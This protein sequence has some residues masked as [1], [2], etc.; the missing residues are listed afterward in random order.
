MYLKI[1]VFK[2]IFLLSICPNGNWFFIV[3]IKIRTTFDILKTITSE[4]NM[5]NDEITLFS[6]LLFHLS[7]STAF[8]LF[9]ASEVLQNL[10]SFVFH[11]NTWDVMRQWGTDLSLKQKKHS[12]PEKKNE[13]LQFWNLSYYFPPVLQ[14]YNLLQMDAKSMKTQ[15]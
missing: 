2:I 9:F 1:L 7:L 6:G 5:K 3:F 10:N 11:K 14:L 13:P 15:N 8:L 4:V 12:L